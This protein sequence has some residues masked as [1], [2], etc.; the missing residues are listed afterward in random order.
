MTQK[1]GV[2]DRVQ[3]NGAFLICNSVVSLNTFAALKA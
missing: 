1:Q 2:N 3:G